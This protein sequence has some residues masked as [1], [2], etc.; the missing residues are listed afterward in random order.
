M[1]LT[2]AHAT[3]TVTTAGTR[4]QINGTAGIYPTAIYFEA[5]KANT[6]NIFIGL[7]TVSST[8]YI[9][10]LPAGQG[11]SI[12]APGAGGNFRSGGQGLDLSVYYADCSVSGE[13]VQV[14][15]LYSTGG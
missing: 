3:K 10:C 15:Y 11:F 12:T 9:S 4:V 5:A 13:K 2:P 6:G 8:V 1:S 14:T 7:V